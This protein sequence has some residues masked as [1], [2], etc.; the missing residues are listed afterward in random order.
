[1]TAL[2][3]SSWLLSRVTLSGEATAVWWLL[4]RTS[5]ERQYDDRLA[6]P[7]GPF[8]GIRVDEWS[9]GEWSEWTGILSRLERMVLVWDEQ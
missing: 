8:S 1:M 4:A 2:I 3:L 5:P 6:D 7:G 9:S